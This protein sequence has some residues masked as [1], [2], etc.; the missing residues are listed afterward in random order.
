MTVEL[1]WHIVAAVLV[2]LGALGFLVS[3][4]AM[5]RVRDAVSRVNCLGPATAVGLPSILVGALIEQTIA[6]GWSW[7]DGVKVVLAVLASLIV[8]SVASNTLGRAAYRSGAPIDPLTD[9][10]ELAGR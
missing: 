10:N 7:G 9:P 5:L 4:I 2:L 6:T 8:S 1:V 3:A